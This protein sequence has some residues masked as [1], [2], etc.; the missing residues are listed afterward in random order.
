MAAA[1]IRNAAFALF[2]LCILLAVLIH[3]SAAPGSAR[4]AAV[5]SV[6]G[7]HVVSGAHY[8]LYPG[9]LTKV[10]RVWFTLTPL[11][12]RDVWVRLDSSRNRWHP[13]VKRLTRFVCE[14]PTPIDLESAT[15]FDVR[16]HG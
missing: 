13:C 2:F 1:S 15:R 3:A 12:A 16:A 8:D 14:L 9:D 5:S 4:G 10:Q 6:P 7:R 11:S